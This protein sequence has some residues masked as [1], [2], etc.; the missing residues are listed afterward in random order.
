MAVEGDDI[1]LLSYAVIIRLGD[2]RILRRHTNA[3]M[4]GIAGLGLAFRRTRL[5]HHEAAAAIA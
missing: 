5:G 2:A 4:A 3:P 1:D